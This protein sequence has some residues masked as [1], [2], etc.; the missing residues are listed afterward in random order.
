M[1]WSTKKMFDF[2]ATLEMLKTTFHEKN[3]GYSVQTDV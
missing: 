1:F 2:K 3:L